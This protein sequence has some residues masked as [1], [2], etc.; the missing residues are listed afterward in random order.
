M[1][2]HNQRNPATRTGENTMQY[3]QL[4]RTGATVSRLC[5]GTMNFGAETDEAESFAIMDR[6]LELGINF[7]DT[8]DVY[9][10]PLGK[11]LTEELIGRWLAQGGG[12]RE[13]IVLA[14]K[15]YGP[16]GPLPHQRG[17]S[18][19]HVRRACDASLRRLGV[20]A[21]DLYQMHHI[22]RGYP[23]GMAPIWMNLQYMDQIGRIDHGPTWEETWQAMEQLV[24]AG[25]ILYVG[26]SNFAAWNIAQANTIA[27]ARG[28][29]GL[30]S[31]QSRYNLATRTAE[32]EVLPAC[33][34]L[35]VGVIPYSPVGGGLLAGV[36]QGAREGRRANLAPQ[37]LDQHRSQLEAYEA[38]CREL[39]EPPATVALAWLL[40]QPGVTAPIVGPRTLEQLEASLRAVDLRLSDEVLK[41]LDEIWPGPGKQAPEAYA[42]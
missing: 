31:E 30:V 38:L 33:R 42:W 18:A 5:L 7:F 20:D 16:M 26:S 8:A 39:G 32:L 1:L 28:F 27:A 13:K 21:L 37:V 35:G 12:R 2:K 41:R 40:H 34:A 11:G 10:K 29:L 6:A 14:T 15:V 3:V 23:S 25:K 36:L 24:A 4:G 17:L 19:L 9:G 22:D